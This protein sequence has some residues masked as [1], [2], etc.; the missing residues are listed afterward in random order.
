M[1]DFEKLKE[2]CRVACHERGACTAGYEALMH[3]DSIGAILAVW[4]ANWEDIYSSKFADVMVE[5]ISEVYRTAKAEM[6]AA[7]FW[8]N[9]DREQGMVIITNAPRPVTLGGTAKGYI[10]AKSEVRAT[11]NAQVY[12]RTDGSE[13]V[14]TGHATANISGESTVHVRQW[15]SARCVS[16]ICYTSDAAEVIA[17]GCDVVSDGHRHITAYGATKVMGLSHRGIELNQDSTFLQLTE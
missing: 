12:C 13:I 16:C 2:I 10:F 4:R 1:T 14:L 15:A 9:E 3:A 5:R 7:G 11:D 6:N 8:V 17:T